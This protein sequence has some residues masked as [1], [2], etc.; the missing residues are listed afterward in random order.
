MKVFGI[1]SRTTD[2]VAEC[3]QMER[4]G[5]TNRRMS[6]GGHGA[7]E[8]LEALFLYHITYQYIYIEVYECM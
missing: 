5:N 8:S 3:K 4:C 7:V 2:N 1:L 6:S